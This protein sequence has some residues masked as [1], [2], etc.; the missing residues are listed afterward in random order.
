[1]HIKALYRRAQGYRHRHEF[2]N[3]QAD[4]DLAYVNCDIE[5][6]LK[7]IKFELK[8]LANERKGFNKIVSTNLS[9][10]FIAQSKKVE[11]SKT[12]WS[13]IKRILC[14]KSSKLKKT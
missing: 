9:A 8:L 14:C 1:M 13:Q 12:F 2:S 5:E 7:V 4:L 11:E 3:A 10:G 6:E